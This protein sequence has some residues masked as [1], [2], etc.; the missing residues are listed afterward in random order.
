MQKI[1]RSALFLLAL[2]SSVV[3]LSAQDEAQTITVVGSGIVNPVLESIIAASATELEFDITTTGTAAALEQF[4]AGTVDIA[5]ASRIL[6]LEETTA[7]RDNAVEYN[8]LLI[9]YDVLA[10]IVNPADAFATCLTTQ[11][12]NTLFAPSASSVTINWNQLND[13]T[14]TAETPGS[15]PDLALQVLVPEDTTLTFAELDNI[16]NGVGFRADATTANLE[17]IIETVRT[18]PGAIGAVPLQLAL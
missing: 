6:S 14:A 11:Q 16:V 15:F 2:L 17:T 7:C 10:V 9:G 13:A 18:T 12:L 4:C 1:W 3:F 8:E 5:T